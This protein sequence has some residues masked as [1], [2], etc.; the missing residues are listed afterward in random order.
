MGHLSLKTW[1]IHP[2]TESARLGIITKNENS[3]EDRSCSQFDDWAVD[4]DHT[5]N[6]LARS[7]G[8]HV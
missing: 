1:D 5:V 3:Y 4:Y 6:D 2:M 7:A 8:D